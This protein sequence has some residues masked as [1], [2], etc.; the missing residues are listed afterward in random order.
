[1]LAKCADQ[2]GEKS[3]SDEALNILPEAFMKTPDM[4]RGDSDTG[5]GWKGVVKV[6]IGL[7]WPMVAEYCDNSE[8]LCVMAR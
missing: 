3:Y 4:I 5:D 6:L 2:E 7:I 1:M 8:E